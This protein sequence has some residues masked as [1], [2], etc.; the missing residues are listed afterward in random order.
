MTHRRARLSSWRPVRRGRLRRRARVGTGC[1]VPRARLVTTHPGGFGKAALRHYERTRDLADG[2]ARLLRPVPSRRSQTPRWSA[3]RRTS[4]VIGREAF[5]VK[6]VHARLLRAMRLRAASLAREGVAI[7][8][9]RL[10]ALRP[11]ALREG[12]LQTSESD[13]PREND[14]AWV[15][16]Q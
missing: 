15:R 16:K 13:M 11:L 6:R 8:P 10:S 1:G 12:H 4:G 7:H 2:E 5:R 3:E 9:E 14:D